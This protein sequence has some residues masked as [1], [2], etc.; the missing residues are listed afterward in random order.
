[1]SSATEENV[2][3]GGLHYPHRDRPLIFS[4]RFKVTRDRVPEPAAVQRGAGM[5]VNRAAAVAFTSPRTRPSNMARRGFSAAAPGSSP[6]TAAARP[7][8]G[9][10]ASS[11]IPP[12]RDLRGCPGRGDGAEVL[13][14]GPVRQADIAAALAAASSSAVPRYSCETIRACRRRGRTPPGSRMWPCRASS[15]RSSHIWVIQLQEGRDKHRHG[16]RSAKT[17]QTRTLPGVT[18]P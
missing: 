15:P 18:R 1:M 2:H 3:D 12:R 5:L 13:V 4:S 8:G 14:P 9:P 10:A 7:G 11:M 6:W 16:A 17:S